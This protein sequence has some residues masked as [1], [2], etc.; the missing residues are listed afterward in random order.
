MSNMKDFIIAKHFISVLNDAGFDAFI[1]GGAVRDMIMNRNPKD[2]DIVTSAPIDTIKELF[3]FHSHGKITEKFLIHAFKFEGSVFEIASFRDEGNIENRND[4][5]MPGNA[6]TDVLRRDF[7]CNSIMWNPITDEIL[8][9]LN[10][11]QDIH[12]GILRTT[13]DS[14]VVFSEDPVRIFRAIRFQRQFGFDF[15]FEINDNMI[16]N[17]LASQNKDRCK[18]EIRKIRKI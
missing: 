10:G 15:A 17:A 7:T 2:F 4:A 14:D 5:V 1:V 3:P 16:K 18:N 6:E 13:R 9:P 12:D 11:V 8:D